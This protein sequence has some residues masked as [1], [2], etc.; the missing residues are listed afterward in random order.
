[1]KN[2]I[3]KLGVFAVVLL[4]VFGAGLGIGAAV[5]PFDEQPP[6]HVEHTP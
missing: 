1:M 3:V 4:V 5:G 6:A 2:P